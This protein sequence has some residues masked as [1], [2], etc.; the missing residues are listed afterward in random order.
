[1]VA[2]KNSNAGG[3]PFSGVW[4]VDALIAMEIVDITMIDDNSAIESG[5]DSNVNNNLEGSVRPLVGC[6][7][8]PCSNVGSGQ[9]GEGSTTV[10]TTPTMP[11]I[12]TPTTLVSYTPG[13][14]EQWI[15]RIEEKFTPM[16]G[17]TFV[18]LES[19]MLFHK[20]YAIACG[21]EARKSSTKRFK[22]GIIR[23]KCMVCHSQGFNNRKRR[24]PQ[25]DAKTTTVETG[26]KT[27][28]GAISGNRKTKAA[29]TST[30]KGGGAGEA[31]SSNKQSVTPVKNWEFEKLVVNINQLNE[32]H[33]QLIIQ[34]S[35]LN[36]GASLTYNLCKEQAEGF[37]NVEATLMQFKNFQRNV[38]CLLNSKD[39]HMFISR[40]ET[41]RETKGLV[42]AYETDADSALTRIFLTNADSIKCYAL[43][44][45]AISFDPTYGTNKYNMK[46]ALFTG[47]DNHKK[48]IIFGCVLLEY[49]DDESFIWAFQQFLKAMGG[50]EPNYIISD[51]DAGIINAV[52]DK[53]GSTICKETDFLSRLNNIVWSEDLEP[54]EFEENWAKVINEFLLEGN[55]WLTGKF[56]ERDQWIPAYFRNVPME[57]WMRFES[58]MDQQRHNLKLLEAHSHNSMPE[59]LFGSNWEAHAVKVYT[60]EVFFDF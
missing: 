13:G 40:L 60:H 25:A 39:G 55:K 24:P 37:E 7:E 42:F 45:D 48:S 30:K 18:D 29:K 49:E 22:D 32:Y 6:G 3:H 5:V 27:K 26:D 14:T 28:A 15:S 1:M 41:L 31:E 59:T 57:F 19:A 36:V 46:F 33:K 23:T 44:G 11:T 2:D 8:V 38:K 56:A 12:S 50:K 54:E 51:Q 53:V 17:K 43:F 16:V 21:F 35:R 20:I 9:A 47:I 10:L 4:L 34:N 52:P 58:A